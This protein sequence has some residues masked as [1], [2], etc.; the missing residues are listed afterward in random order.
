VSDLTVADV[1]R[2]ARATLEA[3]REGRRRGGHR[4]LDRP[5]QWPGPIV[6][7]DAAARVADVLLD[8]AE[9]A[10]AAGE[11][12]GDASTATLGASETV[13][14]M[15]E[16]GR[17]MLLGQ[18]VMVRF[19][20]PHGAFVVGVIGRSSLPLLDDLLL[21]T[22]GG[23]T[24][25]FTVVGTVTSASNF[26]DVPVRIMAWS[27]YG[28][29]TTNETVN[30]EVR[31]GISA[32]GGASFSYGPSRSVGQA[33]ANAVSWDDTIESGAF[34]DVT[35]SAVIVLR[36]EVRDASNLSAATGNGGLMLVHII[37]D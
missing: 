25:T 29:H 9:G 33:R 11:G 12:G 27:S 22:T 16:T 19:E 26:S 10:L 17:A 21:S 20:P 8:A 36:T 23:L 7:F 35:P 28:F 34:L 32:N 24:S 30:C 31:V 15:V 18:R 2:I 5:L 14:A 37:G 4:S 13:P 3:S 6:A 1:E